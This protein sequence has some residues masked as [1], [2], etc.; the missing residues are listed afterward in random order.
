MSIK[1]SIN[2]IITQDIYNLIYSLNHLYN[3]NNL[4]YL[5]NRYLPNISIQNKTKTKTK[6]KFIVNNKQKQ[7]HKQKYKHKHSIPHPNF[8]CKAR[9]W[10][11]KD[12]VKYNPITK[13]WTYGTLCS[14]KKI[15]NSDYCK[16][17][18]KQSLTSYGLTNGNFHEPPPHPHYEK[19]KNIIKQKFNIK[20]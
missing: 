18:H 4:Q 7:K 6:T 9:C 1:L 15:H 20:N 14:K 2:S 10:G 11:G 19:Y 8:R 12:S 5:L 17:H 13:K 3:I 16:T